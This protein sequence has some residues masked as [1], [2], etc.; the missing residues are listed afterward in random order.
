MDIIST[1]NM[2]LKAKQGKYAIPA[3]NIYN[4]E[5]MQAVMEAAANM[6]SPVIL[7]TSPSTIKY[8]GLDTLVSLVRSGI[9]EY[10]IPA[11]LHLDHCTDLE[12][13]RQCISAGYKSVMIDASQESFEENIRKTK[14]AV[15]FAHKYDATVEAELGHVGGRGG[16]DIFTD[17]D[18]ALE[19]VNKT[20]VDSLAIAIGTVHGLYK[21]EPKLDFERLISIEERTN[22]PLVLHGASGVP[23]KS[24]VRAIELGICKI[25]IATELKV[26]FARETG[27]FLQ[28]QPEEM[29]PRKY[30][31]PGKE[32][33]KK[34]AMVKIEIFGSSKKI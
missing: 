8:T 19:F 34:A 9:K 33:I 24:I 4:L 23:D 10:K 6:K 17:P 30:F 1:R 3:F 25:N 15:H 27:K 29:D 18:A 16:E 21:S 12:L 2:L 13:L 28:E 26:P 5:T 32:A 20:D 31:A 11:A 22:V 7:A 14:E